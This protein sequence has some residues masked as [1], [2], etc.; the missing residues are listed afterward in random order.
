MPQTAN[1]DPP[2]DPRRVVVT[3]TT[4]RH[5]VDG[6]IEATRHNVAHGEFDQAILDAL[7]G[8]L[9]GWA[10]DQVLGRIRARRPAQGEPVQ[11]EGWFGTR[12]QLLVAVRPARESD[13][14]VA[15]R[16]RDLK[17]LFLPEAAPAASAA[18]GAGA[19][20]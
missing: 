8:R 1:T 19:V 11:Y 7:K 18:S 17:G 4:I 12:R 15:G 16:K 6:G 3:V 2:E 5:A 9:H 10:L 13:V 14:T 20:A